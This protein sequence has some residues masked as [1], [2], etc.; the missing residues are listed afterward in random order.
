MTQPKPSV[1]PPSLAPRGL[2]RAMGAEFVGVGTSKFD[3]M[4]DDGRMP[5]PKQI[6]GRKIWDRGQ[7]DEAF[8]ELPNKDKANPWDEI[9]GEST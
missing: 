1:L 6:D 2:S 5:Q 8:A 9:Q 4:V 3:E 7:V